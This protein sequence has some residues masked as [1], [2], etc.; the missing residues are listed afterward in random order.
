MTQMQYQPPIQV[1]VQPQVPLQSQPGAAR[2]SLGLRACRT[3]LVAVM[4]LTSTLFAG[5]AHAALPWSTPFDAQKDAAV[6]IVL[7]Q[8]NAEG[9]TTS[10]SPSEIAARSN[11]ANVHGLPRGANLKVNAQS[12]TWAP[13]SVSDSNLGD[14]YNG[15][16]SIHLAGEFAQRWQQAINNGQKLPD[17]YVVH[18]AWGG[19]GFGPGTGTDN[20]WSP[21]RNPADVQSLYPLARRTLALAAQNLIGQGKRVRVIGLHWNQWETDNQAGWMNSAADAQNGFAAQLNGI[22]SALGEADFPIYLYRPR[23]TIYSRRFYGGNLTKFNYIAQGLT[24]LASS[25]GKFRLLDAADAVSA[26]GARLFNPSGAATGERYGIFQ[27]DTVHYTPDVQRWFARKQWDLVFTSGVYGGEVSSVDSRLVSATP[28]APAPGRCASPLA[29]GTADFGGDC[30]HDLLFTN[31]QGSYVIWQMQSGRIQSDTGQFGVAAPWR[32]VAQR[33]FNGDGQT[34]LLWYYPPED[35]YVLWTMG[36]DGRVQ[37]GAGLTPHAP[38]WKVVGVADFD[39]DGKA[40]LLWHNAASGQALVWLMNGATLAP[41]QPG[42][43]LS[44]P[45]GYQI[46]AIA[47]FKGLGRAQVLLHKPASDDYRLWTLNGRTLVA[48]EALPDH[49]PGWSV[50]ATGDVNGDGKAD[51]LWFNAASRGRVTWLMDGARIL[52]GQGQSALPAVQQQLQAAD[53]SGN[54]RVGILLRDTRTGAMQIEDPVSGALTPF[55]TQPAPGWLP[56]AVD[57]LR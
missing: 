47:D 11:L 39:G 28:A 18:I 21:S 31:A 5:L 51:I 37:S 14:N 34:D 35:R 20:R 54:G 17:L 16:A 55:S 32:V 38:G 13:Y 29:T 49:A 48:D 52:G 24:Q 53:F 26:T 10:L 45:A 9:W 1:Q 7:G 30:A 6:L 57:G 4:A 50:W 15:G 27:D 44:L 23:S 8:S 40:D 43:G 56:V 2:C 3:G 33:D 19:Q 22:A 36:R 12:I 42:G 25:G 46:K 41:S